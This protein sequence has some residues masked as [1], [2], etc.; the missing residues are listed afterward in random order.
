MY[1]LS[2][3]TAWLKASERVYD[4][5]VFT[6]IQINYIVRRTLANTH[7]HTRAIPTKIHSRRARTF[8]CKA[9]KQHFYDSVCLLCVEAVCTVYNVHV[10]V[11]NAGN[12]LKWNIRVIHESFESIARHIS[13]ALTRAHTSIDVVRGRENTNVTATTSTSNTNS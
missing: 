1:T 10:C 2:S 11:C 7:T 4:S 8:G 3:C 6:L 5:N 12:A 13:H 9:S